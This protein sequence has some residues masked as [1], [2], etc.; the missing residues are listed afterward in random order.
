M[1]LS[2]GSKSTSGSAQ[3][4]AQPFATSAA[5]SAQDVFNQNQGNLANLTS[6]VTGTVPTLSSN[7]AGLQPLTQQAQG[8]YGDVIGGKY[9][10]PSSNPGL[11]GVL[12]RTSRDVTNQVNS[13]FSMA[14]RYGSGAQN[15]V[16]SRNLADAENQVLYQ[17]YANER[18]LQQ[19]AAAAPGEM[20]AS[21]LAQLLQAAGTGAE[22]PYTGTN[23]LANQLSALFSGGTQKTSGGIGGLLQGVGSLASGAAALSD[24]RLKSN[25]VK[26]GEMDDGLGIYEYDIFDRRE[27]GVMADEVAQLRPWALGPEVMGYRTVM[28]GLL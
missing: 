15:D 1:G 3:K 20:Q 11:Q 4:W 23:A 19:Q 12:D 27:R 6:A 26:L 24:P 8:Y 14:G 2:G 22:L 5:G 21:G 13:Q 9:L 10:D 28:Y 18:G 17:N 7:F 16:L 25:I